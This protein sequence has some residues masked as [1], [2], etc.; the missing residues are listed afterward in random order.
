MQAVAPI[1]PQLLN[2]VGQ[3][4]KNFYYSLACAIV[5]PAGFV[6]GANVG[7]LGVAMAWT[8]GYPLVVSLL[9]YFGAQALDLPF[10]HM[11]KMFRGLAVVLPAAGFALLLRWLL[12]HVAQASPG[13]VAL[14][15]GSATLLVTMAFAYYRE[16]DT[17]A[18]FRGG[19]KS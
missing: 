14:V 17:I 12:A 9:F 3:S 7:L 15:G 6:V 11:A 2:A 5:L 10:W 4:K 16:R 18:S 13:T 1:V 19:K 8:I